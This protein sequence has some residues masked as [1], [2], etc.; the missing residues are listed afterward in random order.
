LSTLKN[1]VSKKID[2]SEKRYKYQRKFDKRKAQIKNKQ[3]YHEYEIPEIRELILRAGD[4]FIIPEEEVRMYEEEAFFVQNWID[5]NFLKRE[6]FDM[7]IN[8]LIISKQV[9]GKMTKDYIPPN[10]EGLDF[11]ADDISPYKEK[12]PVCCHD[13]TVPLASYQYSSN[14]VISITDFFDRNGKIPKDFVY[15]GKP[16]SKALYNLCGINLPKVLNK[17]DIKTSLEVEAI[18]RNVDIDTEKLYAYIKSKT[19]HEPDT[20]IPEICQYHCKPSS[21]GLLITQELRTELNENC[22]ICETIMRLQNAK[23]EYE[24]PVLDLKVIDERVNKIRSELHEKLINLKWVF[25]NPDDYELPAHPDFDDE[26]QQ[27]DLEDGKEKDPEGS[28]PIPEIDEEL[29]NIED[30]EDENQIQDPEDIE[31]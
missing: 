15:H 2:L 14:P 10:P 19:S 11:L 13:Y 12:S 4:H 31:S 26:E 30:L 3:K 20:S 8:F 5:L 29:I 21:R 17:Q 18:I 27:K 9:V 23:S 16:K 28:S 1:L 25:I 22:S 7:A 24:Y 6:A